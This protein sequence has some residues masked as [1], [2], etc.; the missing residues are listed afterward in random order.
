MQKTVLCLAALA[1]TTGLA[2]CGGETAT[3]E[4]VVVDDG[5]PAEGD[6]VVIETPEVESDGDSVTIG[7]DGISA[8]INDGD[9]SISADI[10]ED[11]SASIEI[12]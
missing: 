6:T 9:T 1:A 11:P 2:A 7:S 8:D 12:N 5:A 10:G 3:D 4:T